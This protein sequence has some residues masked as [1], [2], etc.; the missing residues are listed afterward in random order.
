MTVTVNNKSRIISAFADDTR[1]DILNLI[2]KFPN[3]CVSSIANELNL[4]PSAISQQCKLLEL[5]GVV[6]RVRQ[7]QKICYK[8]NNVNPT[9]E[10][11]LDI[12]KEED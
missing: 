4:S 10:K 2:I 7:G 8:I 12:I 5:S 1:I 9:V 3:I 11:L 6:I